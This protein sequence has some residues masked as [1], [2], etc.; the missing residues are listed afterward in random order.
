MVVIDRSVPGVALYFASLS[1]LR[2]VMSASPYFAITSVS[3]HV[4]KRQVS[5]LHKLTREGN[6]ISGAATRVFVG[7]VRESYVQYKVQYLIH[8]QSTLL[9]S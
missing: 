8:T 3:T 9:L 2:A 4:G 7:F 5:A 1:Q 6:L